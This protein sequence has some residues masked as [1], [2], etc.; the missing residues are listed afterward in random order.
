[1]LWLYVALGAYLLFAV[2]A[3]TDRYLLA[4]PLPHPRLY[5]FYAGVS[6]IFATFLIPFGFHIPEIPIVVLSFVAGGVGVVALFLFYRA[7]FYGKV[8]IVVPGVG[9]MIPLFTLAFSALVFGEELLITPNGAGALMLLILGTIFLSLRI[10]EHGVVLSY[11]NIA[12]M[13]FAAAAFGLAFVLTKT[14]FQYETFI[15]GFVF[16][17]WGGFLTSISFLVLPRTRMR[18]FKVSS[19]ATPR[20]VFPFLIGK[21]AG[22]LGSILQN[23]AIFLASVTQIAFIS[24]L[25]SFEYL[26]LLVFVVLLALKNPKILK[27]EL[28]KKSLP[29]RLVGIVAVSLGLIL[30]VI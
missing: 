14:V 2:S 3:I 21:G 20:V 28:N 4:G 1:M 17:A 15:T 29:L 11:R 30:L 8:S 10:G 27:E 22:S 23:Y 16:M 6:G 25:T 12:N 13:V 26:F 18:A 19:F 5:A 7:I 9:A 24:A